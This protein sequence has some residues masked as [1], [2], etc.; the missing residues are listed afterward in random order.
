MGGTHSQSVV[1]SRVNT[2]VAEVFTDVALTC[3]NNT[4][5]SQSLT[6]NCRPSMINGKPYEDNPN[7]IQCIRNVENEI[8]DRLDYLIRIQSR[9]YPSLAD[10]RAEVDAKL[11]HCGK[12][13]CKAC[14]FENISQKLVASNVASCQA[15][16]SINNTI[17]Q[18]LSDKVRQ[19]LTDH[20]DVL[21]TLA[22][23]FGSDSTEAVVNHVT[24]QLTARIKS[25]IV[26]DIQSTISNNQTLEFNNGTS[27]TTQNGS[28]TSVVEY[29]NK[30]RVFNQ[31]DFIAKWDTYQESYNKN[32]TVNSA[33]Q[34]VGAV[35]STVARWINNTGGQVFIAIASLLSLALIAFAIYIALR[36]ESVKREARL[37]K[38]SSDGEP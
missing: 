26:N 25:N 24:N 23:V 14:V 16:N 30:Q 38:T 33:G 35:T 5:L 19:E 34:I 18:K 10:L 36:V 15:M 29:L 32:T 12:T 28:V 2:M 27:N 3:N 7:C 17:A 37:Q 21:G 22:Q 31:V 13:K 8:S 11:L 4:S 1:N 6:V 9:N 20:T